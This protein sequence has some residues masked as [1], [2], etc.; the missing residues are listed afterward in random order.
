[1]TYNKFFT[2]LDRLMLKIV[3]NIFLLL[4]TFPF[5]GSKPY[6][7]DWFSKTEVGEGGAARILSSL[8]NADNALTRVSAQQTLFRFFK[9]IFVV[10]LNVLLVLTKRNFLSLH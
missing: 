6:L 3:F 7:A 9:F 10:F 1:M 2:H 5:D 8:S 4:A